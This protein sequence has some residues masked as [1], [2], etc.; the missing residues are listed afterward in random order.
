MERPEIISRLNLI[1][2][3]IFDDTSIQIREDYSA[4]DI[5]G[6]D[7]LTHINIIVEAEKAFGVKFTTKEI[8][9]LKD[10]SEFVDLIMTKKH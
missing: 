9:G 3:D 4:K 10:V 2:Q 7:S 6:W 8:R 1:F 5:D